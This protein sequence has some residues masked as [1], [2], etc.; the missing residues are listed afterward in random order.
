MRK[1][2]CLSADKINFDDFFVPYTSTI[3]I[4]WPHA[5][6]SVLLSRD[7]P[8]SHALDPAAKGPA[9][10]ADSVVINPAFER[11]LYDLG[12]W[13]LGPAFRKQFPALADASVRIT[14]RSGG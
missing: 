11:H 3:S 8:S 5:P 6:D 1:Q 10:D 13:S 14:E 2:F 12:N 4:N 7:R 9:A